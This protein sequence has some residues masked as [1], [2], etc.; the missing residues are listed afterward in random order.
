M[1]DARRIIRAMRPEW[2][3]FILSLVTTLLFVLLNSASVWMLGSVVYT[4][5]AGPSTETVLGEMGGSINDLLKAWTARWITGSTPVETLVRVAI[6][7]LIVF[8]LKSVAFYVKNTSIS[9]MQT[10]LLARLRSMLF[11]RL[12]GLP[13]SFYDHRHSGELASVVINDVAKVRASLTGSLQRILTEPVNVVAFMGILFII[14]WRLTLIAVL[15]LP[16]CALLI[17]WMGKSIRRKSQRTSRQIAGVMA[18]LQE[19]LSGM[20]VVQAFAM[21]RTE[22]QRFDAESD[23]FSRLLFRQARLAN[24]S[25]PATEMIGVTVGVILLVYGGRE[26]LSGQGITSE[27]FV[28]FLFVLFSVMQ[29]VRN[30]ARVNSQIQDGLAGARRI[31]ALIDT[32]PEIRDRPDAVPLHGFS[33][34]IRFAGVSL[35]YQGAETPALSDIDLEIPV[36]SRIALVGSSGA[37]KSSLADLIPR[38]YDVSAGQV[39]IDGRDLRSFTLTSLRRMVGVV[40]QDTMLFSSSVADN[41]RYGRP[42]ASQAEVE[43]AAVAANASAFIAEMPEGFATLVGERGV[44]LSGGQRQRIAIARAI[45]KDPPLLILDE[46]TSSLDSEA[47]REVQHAIDRLVC[48]RT[49]LVIAHR[50]STVLHA[51]E[52][53]V[54]DQ[55]R[56]VERGKHQELLTQGGTYQRLYELQF[57]AE[58]GRDD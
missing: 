20:R 37:G 49:V 43:A 54:L 8:F 12:L 13:M 44:R 1:H 53:V 45:L 10:R 14:S 51:D 4:I 46:A 56:I 47:E 15:V 2:P 7:L 33:A 6:T 29:P 21:E 41:I 5:F 11:D 19:A 39:C 16:I 26:V 36:G 30:L 31:F 50:L 25:S 9:W 28:R 58:K 57:A 55:G 40:P 34:G 48:G 42:E 23:R 38:F 27:D 18:V 3:I 22:S 32:E 35:R 17:H 24:L 52:I